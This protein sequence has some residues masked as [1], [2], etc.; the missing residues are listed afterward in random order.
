[1]MGRV[2]KWEGPQ[3]KRGLPPKG[4]PGET[5]CPQIQGLS[6]ET[7]RSGARLALGEQ[8]RVLAGSEEARGPHC[9]LT[10]MSGGPGSVSPRE[11]GG[12]MDQ[13]RPLVPHPPSAPLGR[14]FL[15]PDPFAMASCVSGPT[16]FS[17]SWRK[18]GVE[19]QG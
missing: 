8:T 13:R 11:S 1:M 12:A 14:P 5:V 17:N 19:A 18:P 10:S 2:R 9:V 3:P 15:A 16:A 4:C 7:R 6:V